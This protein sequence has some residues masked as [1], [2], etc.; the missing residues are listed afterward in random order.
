MRLDVT[1]K[2]MILD[3]VSGDMG[4]A[5]GG[6]NRILRSMGIDSTRRG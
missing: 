5:N 2:R 4:E 1:F 6:L 3:V